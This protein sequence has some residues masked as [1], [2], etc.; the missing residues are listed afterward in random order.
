[1]AACDDFHDTQRLTRRALIGRG[2]AAGL[3]LY[4]ARGLDLAG[5]LD[6][7]RALAL[8][9]DTVLVSVFLPGGLDLLDTLVPSGGTGRY[10][11][12]RRATRPQGRLV[13][14]GTAGLQLHPAL[15]AGTG[16][17]VAALARAGKIA[18]LPGI[19][20]ANPDLSHFHSRHF[21]ESGLITPKTAPGWLGRWLDRAGGGNPFAGVSLTG[22]LSPVLHTQGA[23]VVAVSRPADAQ[24]GMGG[25]WGDVR[26]HAWAT[27]GRLAA[28]AA[29]RGGPAGPQSVARAAGLVREVADRLAPYVP[30]DGLPDP[31]VGAT[32][33]PADNRLGESLRNLAGMLTLPLGIRVAAVQAD[34]DFDTHDTQRPELAR[35]LTSVS[36]AL[37]AFQA[38]LV[39]RGLAGRV[40]TLVWSEFGRRPE[41]NE[42]GG[43][44][45][46]AGG[47]AWLMGE[48]VR[49]GVLSDYPSLKRFDGGGNLEVTLDF[50]RLYAS[51]LEQWLGT[52]AAAVL[53]GAA[54]HGRLAVVR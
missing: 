38:D 53:P 29:A 24:V 5:S 4:G 26:D 23:P 52:D 12:L 25:V 33:Y 35:D 44:D 1:M 34:V 50:R 42:S 22:G 32:Q 2:L 21:W 43:T 46:G 47:L 27:Y 39:A 17:G 7:A 36:E 19:D 14:S 6:T 28:G 40:L 9:T 16:G 49:G 10:A 31:L 41:A 15:A 51:L 11:D 18:F 54:R 3:T 13:E 45:H 30:L 8:P 37:A 20:Y 48:R